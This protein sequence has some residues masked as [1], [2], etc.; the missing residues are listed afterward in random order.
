MRLV[1]PEPVLALLEEADLAGD[2][3]ITLARIGP[4]RKE[5]QVAR[6]DLYD[7]VDAIWWLSH[8]ISVQ[9]AG[10]EGAA[11][12]RLR[13]HAVGG[14]RL[15]GIQFT[16]E[17]PPTQLEVGPQSGRRDSASTVVVEDAV[18][19]PVM[20]V[21]DV[22]RAP[23]LRDRLP[24]RHG[25]SIR[26]RLPDRH[27]G[28]LPEVD[29][30]VRALVHRVQDLEAALAARSDELLR[31]RELLASARE[32]E[33]DRKERCLRAEQERDRE[34]D[35][36]LQVEAECEEERAARRAAEV[37]VEELEAELAEKEAADEVLSEQIAEL[38][39]LMDA[40]KWPFFRR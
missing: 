14:A 36:R 26:D 31:V 9:D 6:L 10:P 22:G 34:R 30:D 29:L 2:G 11:R 18:S 13:H 5:K 7:G 33:I 35:A 37:A 16:A 1:D 12:L 39:R 27:G 28:R 20:S 15:N 25:A 38:E 21:S 40:P 32:R 23:S 3:Y 19:V 4:K 24:D 8:Q 17:G